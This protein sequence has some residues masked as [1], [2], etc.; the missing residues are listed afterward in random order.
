MNRKTK[1][2]P[3]LLVMVAAAQAQQAGSSGNTC[4]DSCPDFVRPVCG[5][6][7][8]AYRNECHLQVAAC[9]SNIRKRNDG[10]C[11]AAESRDC[12]RSC[13]TS[14]QPFC[15]TN[16]VTY[17]NRCKLAIA[18]CL[19]ANIKERY[20]G[21]CPI[22]Y[23]AAESANSGSSGGARPS[24]QT[25]SN[26]AR[27]SVGQAVR[28]VVQTLSDSS[29]PASAPASVVNT[30]QPPRN[31]EDNCTPGFRPVCG[32]DNQVYGNDCLLRVAICKNPRLGKLNDGVCTK[33]CNIA[34]PLEINY[35]CGSN[36]I[37]YV[38]DCE[39]IVAQC[40]D[41]A[42]QKV[43]DGQ[44]AGFRNPECSA[45]N[46]ERIANPVCGSD[47]RTYENMCVL[48]NRACVD[49]S[50]L[51]LH[52]GP[53]SAQRCGEACPA[54]A[55]PVCGSDGITYPNHC[56]LINEACRARSNVVKAF[57]GACRSDRG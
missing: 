40:K 27:P 10:P 47:G 39:L 24:I 7:N 28:P 56:I 5:T 1:L 57:D 2:A 48:R 6:N 17:D 9:N 3:F 50:L 49:N 36:R 29:R 51:R 35:V 21:V 22:Q 26:G 11:V 18:T 54:I 15:A 8:L 20:E 12:D 16:G 34:C 45:Q 37:T 30:Q 19:D 43:S 42:V 55:D 14:Y 41:P 52:D 44:C 31:C 13:P 38:N 23:S 4:P 33:D 32:T 46:C 53:C 25:S